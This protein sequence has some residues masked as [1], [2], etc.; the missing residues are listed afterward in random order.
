MARKPG[1]RGQHSRPPEEP[2]YPGDPRIPIKKTEIRKNRI[3]VVPRELGI[4]QA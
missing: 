3:P 2:H 4:A 1:S